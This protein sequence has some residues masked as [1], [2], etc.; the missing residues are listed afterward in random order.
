MTKRK[1]PAPIRDALRHESIES[2]KTE[3]VP[4][5]SK[6]IRSA[7]RSELKWTLYRYST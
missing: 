5:N 4:D 7:A 1:P 3:V 2:H 6:A